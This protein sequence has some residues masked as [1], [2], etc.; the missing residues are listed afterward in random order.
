MSNV[1]IIIVHNR[2][3]HIEKR[4]RNHRRK[5][6]ANQKQSINFKRNE[7]ISIVHMK[8]ICN[9]YYTWLL[10]FLKCSEPFFRLFR[11]PSLSFLMVFNGRTPRGIAN[12]SSICSTW[13]IVNISTWA[14]AAT[15]TY[16][17]DSI[18]SHRTAQKIP[19]RRLLIFT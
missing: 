11:W 17:I 7:H 6:A 1:C 8:A 5:W 14:R 12:F 13:I 10:D 16:I 19:N 3:S 4:G 18:T 2:K 15:L 9:I